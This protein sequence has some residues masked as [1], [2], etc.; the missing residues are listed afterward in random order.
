MATQRLFSYCIPLD[1]GAA[2]NPYWGYCTLN[3]CKPVIRRIANIGDWVV[4]TGS[5]K[6][7]FAN[8]VVYAMK[9]TKKMTMKE[10]DQWVKHS[11]P[12]KE[13]AWRSDDH[14]R[15]LGDS[16]YDFSTNPPFQRKGVHKEINIKTDLGGE[17]TLISDHFYYFGDRSVALLP[18]L[19][20]IVKQGQGHRSKSNEPYVDR[21]V[22]WIENLG[23]KP[24][25]LGGKP[26]IDLFAGT[27]TQIECAKIRATISQGDEILGSDC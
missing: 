9:I 23:V 27:E 2:P 12:Q 18:D 5:V 24:N 21:F 14:K 6:S 25:V 4:G 15:R 7:D 20:P 1:D 11:C 13:P 17:Y 26:Q 19:H 3:I 16:I 8:H 10:Y 22:T